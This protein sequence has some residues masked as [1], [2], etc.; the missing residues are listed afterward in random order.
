MVF[1]IQI[2]DDND[3]NKKYKTRSEWM[4]WYWKGTQPDKDV[5]NFVD[6]NYKPGTTYADF[7]K[8]VCN[9]LLFAIES[10]FCS[11]PQSI[12]MRINL[13]KL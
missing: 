6:K 1:S 10:D 2:K 13:L 5:V 11:L 3:K 12:S 8:D 7:A 4:W 9:I